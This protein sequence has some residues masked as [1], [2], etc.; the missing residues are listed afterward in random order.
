MPKKTFYID[1]DDLYEMYVDQNM[2]RKDIA[3]HYGCSDVLIKKT[4][5]KYDIQKTKEL[6]S[7][8]K[9][10]R[11]SKNCLK[12]DG[13][14]EIVRFRSTGIYEQFFCS[15]ACSA[16]DRDLGSEHR[17]A[18]RTLRSARRRANLHKASEG[19]TPEETEQIRQIY[20][21]RP[22]GYEVD[23]IIPLSKGGKHCPDNLQYLTVQEN[24]SKGYKII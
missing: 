8:N 17:T 2:M 24:R 5:H 19:L 6:E 4:L 11:V 18:M 15:H 9:E 12:C 20:L 23:H 1:K 3:D 13:V 22:E 10:R 16:A 7:K 14:F 21:N